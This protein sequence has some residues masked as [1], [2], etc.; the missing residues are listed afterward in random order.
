MTA[1]GRSVRERRKKSRS[2]QISNRRCLSVDTTWPKRADSVGKTQQEGAILPLRFS[3][4]SSSYFYWSVLNLELVHPMRI[5]IERTQ[6]ERVNT[7]TPKG[8]RE[9]R[10]GTP[11]SPVPTPA[12]LHKPRAAVHTLRDTFFLLFPRRKNSIRA[13]K[14]C[15]PGA[16]ELFNGWW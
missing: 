7:C 10:L 1:D 6:K 5:Y 12:H 4:S 15:L 16:E 13:Q 11:K 8:E 14:C 9:R 3:S 2:P